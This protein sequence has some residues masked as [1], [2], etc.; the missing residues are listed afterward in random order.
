MHAN[1]RIPEGSTSGTCSW[2]GRELRRRRYFAVETF[3]LAGHSRYLRFQLR[4]D[5]ELAETSS[6]RNRAM[7]SH[8]VG[9]RS[10]QTGKRSSSHFQS[11]IASEA[12]FSPFL[13][14]IVASLSL[15]MIEGYCEPWKSIK[16]DPMINVCQQNGDPALLSSRMRPS[17]GASDVPH[18]ISSPRTK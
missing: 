8:P 18:L 9:A 11:F 16:T 5:P 7:V 12:N 4:N 17:R 14:I 2:Q 15:R 13:C 1:A 10:S 6:P 3:A